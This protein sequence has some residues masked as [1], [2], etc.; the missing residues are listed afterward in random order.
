MSLATFYLNNMYSRLS[1]FRGSTWLGRRIV[2]REFSEA[3]LVS[4]E[5]YSAFLKEPLFVKE[6][7]EA[8]SKDSVV[9]DVGAFHGAYSILGLKGELVHCFEMDGE[10]LGALKRNLEGK[11]SLR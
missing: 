3:N 8:V 10:N 9:C 7:E 11:R 5:S 6:F 1:G 2:Q 4:K